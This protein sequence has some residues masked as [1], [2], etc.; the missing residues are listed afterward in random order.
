M[1][2]Q[3]L[4][5]NSMSRKLLLVFP[6]FFLEESIEGYV[7]LLTEVQTARN[8]TTNYLNCRIQTGKDLEEVVRTVLF[9]SKTNKPSIPK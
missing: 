2:I 8:F 4:L 1:L 3:D 6:I 5:Q 9:T 7:H